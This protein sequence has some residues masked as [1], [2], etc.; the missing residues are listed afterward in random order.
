MGDWAELEAGPC[1]IPVLQASGLGHPLPVPKL[2]EA[3]SCQAYL[4]RRIP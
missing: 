1:C 4:L 2:L 3:R